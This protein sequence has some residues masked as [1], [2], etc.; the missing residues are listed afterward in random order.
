MVKDP[1]LDNFKKLK[2]PEVAKAVGSFA[3]KNE[4]NLVGT[5]SRFLKKVHNPASDYKD[6]VLN[7]A[8]TPLGEKMGKPIRDKLLPIVTS[9]NGGGFPKGLR[10]YIWQTYRGGAIQDPVG[11]GLPQ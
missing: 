4:Q 6:L 11:W 8:K 9:T 5:A 10:H 3:K 1:Y 2:V 7:F